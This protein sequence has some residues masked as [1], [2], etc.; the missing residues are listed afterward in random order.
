VVYKRIGFVAAFVSSLL[1]P[2]STI[3]NRTYFGLG[4]LP[5]SFS[6]IFLP[7]SF[8]FTWKLLENQI[9]PRDI[10]GISFILSL[11]ILSH[12]MT[13]AFSMIT[14]LIFILSYQMIE[15]KFNFRA[16]L[17][18]GTSIILGI[19]LSSWWLLP[20]YFEIAMP[21]APPESI[22]INSTPPLELLGEFQYLKGVSGTRYLGLSI[23]ILAIIC[24]LKKRDAFHISIF[25][26]GLYSTIF[27]LGVYT[28][29]FKF[30]PLS[31]QIFPDYVLYNS[32]FSF[33]LLSGALLQDL[34]EKRESFSSKI[35]RV[36]FVGIVLALCI[37]DFSPS[38]QIHNRREPLN[39]IETS[40]DIQDMENPG[41]IS[42]LG[43][44]SSDF[45]Y[46]VPIITSRGIVEGFFIQ[47]TQHFE[48]IAT[49]NFVI[50]RDFPSDLIQKKYSQWNVR[51]VITLDEYSEKIENSPPLNFK[52]ISNHENLHLF[53]STTPSS[54]FQVM[55]R[56][57]LVV[58]RYAPT[59]AVLFPWVAEGHSKYIDDYD[60]RYLSN[61]KEIILYGFSYRDKERAEELVKR[62]V[63]E[64]GV[65]VIDL[66]GMEG[67][68]WETETSFYE[69]DAIPIEI[70]GRLEIERSPEL[71]FG[72]LFEFSP[73][74]YEGGPWRSVVYLA[75]DESF[76]NIDYLDG[77]YSIFG[78]K[79]VGDGRIY[80]VGLNLFYHSLINEDENSKELLEN[81]LDLGSPSKKLELRTFEII[82]EEWQDESIYFKYDAP[83]TSLV[84]SLT[85]SPNWRAFIDSKNVKVYN[86]ENLILLFLPEGRHTVY[87]EYGTTSFETLSKLI[88][89]F[90]LFFIGFIFKRSLNRT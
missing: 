27:A 65:V 49:I 6:L 61:F 4:G 78:Y 88:S 7:L 23:L 18:F 53:S 35:K 54:Y 36:I 69:V 63:E 77:N 59:V 57:I 15:G 45:S 66:F 81:L 60:W 64:G 83:E 56:E 70:E 58:G 20:A 67:E 72:E 84:I 29:I 82:E 31:K 51:Y 16:N 5:A 19:L 28:P 17:A 41:R 71:R 33:V 24:V 75:L 25:I 90:T 73:F 47:G 55:D 1:F 11:F 52:E 43:P 9:K 38:S 46:Y 48:E 86:Y 87:L 85:F 14:L 68:W 76:A 42:C 32:I 80:F 30:L 8:Y 40:K 37:L 3:I 21:P 10:V 62:F 79:N 74:Y 22:Q 34:Y 50:K 2:L 39:F 12:A 26:V 89:I 44:F 13:A